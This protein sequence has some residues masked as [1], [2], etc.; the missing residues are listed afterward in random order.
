VAE[1]SDFFSFAGAL[2]PARID[3]FRNGIEVLEIHQSLA[4]IQGAI[5]PN[6]FAP[7]PGAH[8]RTRCGQYR[9]AFGQSMPQPPIGRG[10]Q[11]TDVVLH[12]IIDRDGKIVAPVIVQSDRPD[13]NPEALQL[14][15]TWTFQP[16]MCDGH[17]NTAEANFV[18]H[19][20]G[21]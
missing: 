15:S 19:F 11:N 6:V 4:P 14:I 20:Q 9:R 17:P 18:L 2:W 21:R 3:V 13:L 12:G 7:P 16:A 5:D 8:V 10:S 1:N